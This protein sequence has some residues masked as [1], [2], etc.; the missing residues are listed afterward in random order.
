MKYNYLIIFIFSFLL[1]SYSGSKESK[2]GTSASAS[3]STTASAPGSDSGAEGQTPTT[4]LTADPTAENPKH[5]IFSVP[6]QRIEKGTFKMG[7]LPTEADRDSDEN[8][9]PVEISKAFEIM[10]YELTQKQWFLLK[11]KNPSDF[12][13]PGDCDDHETY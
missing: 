6:F 1:I 11:R 2:N 7:S 9:V 13:N 10:K 12:K 5:W 3:T 4:N 8:Q